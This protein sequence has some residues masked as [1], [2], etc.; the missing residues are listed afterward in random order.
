M[1][2]GK[3]VCLV[4]VCS[5]SL[6]SSAEMSSQFMQGCPVAR[7]LSFPALLTQLGLH[8]AQRIPMPGLYQLEQVLPGSLPPHTSELIE[9][10]KER[11]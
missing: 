6:F 2:N 8:Q 4:C 1:T 10:P 9:V 5:S 7:N 3:T 11:R